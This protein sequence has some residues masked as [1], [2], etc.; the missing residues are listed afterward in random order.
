MRGAGAVIGAEGTQALI[1]PFSPQ[2]SVCVVLEGMLGIALHPEV[3]VPW[4]RGVREE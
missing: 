1:P 2:V 4:S 3:T